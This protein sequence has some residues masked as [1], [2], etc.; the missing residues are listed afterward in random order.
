MWANSERAGATRR[1]SVLSLVHMYYSKNERSMHAW[2]QPRS[3]AADGIQATQRR[4]PR[5]TRRTRW[6]WQ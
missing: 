4:K 2:P 6:R 3:E 1:D 5:H